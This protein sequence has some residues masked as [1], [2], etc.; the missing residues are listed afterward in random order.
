VIDLALRDQLL[1][2]KI[3]KQIEFARRHTW[4]VRVKSVLDVISGGNK[5]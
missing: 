1:G 5:R 2:E 3:I 4:E